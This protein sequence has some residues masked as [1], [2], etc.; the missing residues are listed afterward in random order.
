MQTSWALC[1]ITNAF[2]DYR[3]IKPLSEEFD[4]RWRLPII[5]RSCTHYLKSFDILKSE[6]KKVSNH[7]ILVKSCSIAFQ[8]MSD[9]YSVSTILL[10]SLLIWYADKKQCYTIKITLIRQCNARYVHKIQ[11]QGWSW[12]QIATTHS[13]YNN[14]TEIL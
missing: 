11:L 9:E 8:H 4:A 7:Y 3:F 6:I 2:I 12:T 14:Q 5:F 13:A 10:L 1:H